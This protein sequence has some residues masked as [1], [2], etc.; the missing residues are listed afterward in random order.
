MAFR[1]ESEYA[2][3]F[4]EWKIMDGRQEPRFKN[5]G[6]LGSFCRFHRDRGGWHWIP[7]PATQMTRKE[8]IS[9]LLPTA[10]SKLDAR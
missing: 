8:G 3:W 10:V 1:T 5:D 6:V 4:C 9:L 7:F 2:R